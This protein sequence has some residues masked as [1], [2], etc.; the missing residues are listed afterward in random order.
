MPRGN[1]SEH[2]LTL[3]SLVQC[4]GTL[5]SIVSAWPLLSITVSGDHWW[6]PCQLGSLPSLPCARIGGCRG[7]ELL[8][9]KV[10]VT[11][12]DP[13]R[14]FSR[15]L[16]SFPVPQLCLQLSF[17]R[18]VGFLVGFHFHQPG[19]PVLMRFRLGLSFSAGSF[20]HLGIISVACFCSSPFFIG[21]L[22]LFLLISRN[23]LFSIG[24]LRIE[25]R[26]SCMLGRY[27]TAELHPNWFPG[28]IWVFLRQRLC[29]PV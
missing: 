16:L 15:P 26:A 29:S 14:R 24:V 6:W 10:T 19:H 27:F 9:R 11:R 12:L 8:S 7:L 25:C 17:Q 5:L 13:A 28:G 21:L 23:L 4:S 18:G 22:S 1:L 2:P 20:K 3:W